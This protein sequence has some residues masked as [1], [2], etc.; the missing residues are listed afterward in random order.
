MTRDDLPKKVRRPNQIWAM[1]TREPPPFTFCEMD[2]LNGVFNWTINYRKDSDIWGPYGRKLPNRLGLN[3][4]PILIRNLTLDQWVA[5]KEELVTQ[6]VSRC[7][8][9]SQREALVEKLK[10]AGLPIHV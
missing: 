10:Q 8:T 2:K 4:T 7:K 9:Y 3:K 1:H 5:G 6:V